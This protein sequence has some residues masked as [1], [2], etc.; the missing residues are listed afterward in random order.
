MKTKIEV[1]TFSGYLIARDEYSK[2]LQGSELQDAINKIKSELNWDLNLYT[3][4]VEIA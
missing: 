1:H 2:E 4:T 3:L